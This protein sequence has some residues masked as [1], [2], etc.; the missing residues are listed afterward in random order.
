MS[1]ES[2][3]GSSGWERSQ[4]K[5][6]R[7]GTRDLSLTNTHSLSAKEGRAGSQETERRKGEIGSDAHGQG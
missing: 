1:R 5:E 2:R 4:G 3:E 6:E 7:N